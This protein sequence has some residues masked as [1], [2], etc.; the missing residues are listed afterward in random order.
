MANT[1]GS[2]SAV[3]SGSTVFANSAIDVFG[4]L[5]SM[6][7]M[8]MSRVMRKPTFCICENK[9]ADQLRSDREADQRLCFR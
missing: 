1:V 7:E 6:L 8:Y 5:Q 2:S 3:S 9:D 4:A